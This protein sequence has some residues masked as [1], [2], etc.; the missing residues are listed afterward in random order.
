M[1]LA[2]DN[3]EPLPPTDLDEPLKDFRAQPLTLKRVSHQDGEFRMGGAAPA[4]QTAHGH[5][6][7]HPFVR[8]LSVGH[9]DQVAVLIRETD[10]GQPFVGHPLAEF[11]R[12]HVPEVHASLR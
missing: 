7:V 6:F 8:I 10:V 1:D 3:G 4:A 2:A 9:Q 11:E 12:V 5:N